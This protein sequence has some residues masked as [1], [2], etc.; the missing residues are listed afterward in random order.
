MFE[1]AG[2]RLLNLELHP[3]KI[4]LLCFLP[5]RLLVFYLCRCG[6]NRYVTL[7]ASFLK[8]YPSKR[9]AMPTLS[10]MVS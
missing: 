3:N 8:V 2:S 1:V 10:N 7:D 5:S 4:T 6:K 9:L